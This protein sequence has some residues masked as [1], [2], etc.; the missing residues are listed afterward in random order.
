[1]YGDKVMGLLL[2][3]SQLSGE[4]YTENILLSCESDADKIMARLLET[5]VG[6]ETIQV[7]IGGELKTIPISTVITENKR[8]IWYKLVAVDIQ[9][10][11]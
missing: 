2:Y 8:R 6:W 10:A 4:I 3:S 1:M 11:E 7:A 5:G 9:E